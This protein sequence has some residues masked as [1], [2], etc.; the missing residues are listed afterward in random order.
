MGGLGQRHCRRI[1]PR[2]SASRCRR[3]ENCYSII[4]SHRTIGLGRPA[5]RRQGIVGRSR[6]CRYGR[7]HWRCRIDRQCNRSRGSR[8]I[9]GSIRGLGGDGM[10]GLGQCRCGRKTPRASRSG[11]GRPE[12]RDPVIDGHRAVGLGRPG[13]GW[14]GIVGRS[15]GC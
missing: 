3:P 9:P 6:C 12:N 11:S 8:H 2:T 4:D 13:N 10:G 7:G 5:D 1:T 14:L 15:R